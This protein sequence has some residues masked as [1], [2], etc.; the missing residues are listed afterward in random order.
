MPR[1]LVPQV[2]Y[3]SPALR[4]ES[5]CCRPRAAAA[6]AEEACR[7]HEIVFLRDGLFVKEGRDHQVVADPNHVLFFNGGEPYRISHPAPGGD[8]CLALSLPAA[9]LQD[10]LER[11][12]PGVREHPEAPFRRTHAL[13]SARAARIQRLLV[14]RMRRSAVPDLGVEEMALEL[15]AEILLPAPARE[16]AAAGPV[17]RRTRDAHRDIVDAARLCLWRRLGEPLPLFE[18]ARAVHCAPFHLC[19]L[20]KR[21]TCLTLHRYRQSLRLRVALERLAEGEQSLTELALDLG[22]ADHSHFTTSFRREFHLSPSAFR[23]AASA[24]HL[25]EIGKNLQV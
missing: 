12:D 21:E 4:A 7:A 20:F 11:G 22:F 5:L 1:T 25:R 15:L 8:D 3:E 13:L 19:R 9:D 23:R 14:S 24:R 16:P 6:G 17:K 2:L 10:L 18:L